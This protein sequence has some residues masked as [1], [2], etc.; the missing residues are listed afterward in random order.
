MA[1]PDYGGQ[2]EAP[3]GTFRWDGSKIIPNQHYRFDQFS[4]GLVN[5]PGGVETN[6]DGVIQIELA[7]Y[8]SDIPGQFNILKAPDD[9]WVQI[10]HLVKP[11]IT[12]LHIPNTV[13]VDWSTMGRM[14]FSQWDNFSG[15]CA[16]VHVPENTHWDLP[17]PPH[18]LSIIQANLFTADPPKVVTPPPVKVPTTPTA[19]KFPLPSGHYFG[20]LSSD[21]ACHS[22]TYSSVDRGNIRVWQQQMHNR[23]WNI[24]VDGVYGSQSAGICKQFQ[25]EKHLTVDGK[26]GPQT[27]ATSWS[28]PVT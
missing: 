27:W 8:L 19:P 13:P 6:R 22:G 9:Y 14:G 18:A 2:G 12:D 4:K 15:I 5:A 17:I 28:A 23:G 11:I 1:L 16:H 24:T 26:V 21:L 20:Q 10:A 3:H 7:G 25:A